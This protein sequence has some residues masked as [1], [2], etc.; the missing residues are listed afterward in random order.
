MEKRRVAVVG[1]GTVCP[2]GNSVEDAW[3]AIKSG[4]SGIGR[5]TCFDT[6]TYP[7]KIA[8]EVKGFSVEDYG[9]E[10]KAVRKMARFTQLVVASSVQAIN[11]AHLSKEELVR[12]GAGVCVG[13]CMGGL[14]AVDEGYRKLLAS[15]TGHSKISPLTVP[16]WISSEA[17]A[18]VSIF[19]GLQGPSYEVGTACASGTDAIG[20][21]ADLVKSGRLDV[22]LAGGTEASLTEFNIASLMQLQALTTSGNDNP[23][24]ASRPF[25]AT[26]DGF[27]FSEGSAILVLEEMT[28]AQKRGAHIYAEIAGYGS[29]CDAY[30]ITAPLADGSGAALAMRRALEDAAVA[31]E[32]IDYYNAHGT[33]T[34]LN[35]IAETRMLKAVF[36]ESVRSLSVSSTKSM[37]GHMIAAAGAVEAVFCV[38]AIEEGFVPPTINLEHPDTENDLDLDYTPNVGHPRKIDFAASASL[39]F[40]GHNGCLIFKAM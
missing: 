15:E 32:R 39:G 11:D 23:T 16:L 37:T 24:K 21:A 12:R 6:T 2:V 18:N 3:E 14:D 22:C 17:A 20:I 7:V 31:P 10:R 40:G 4:T 8:G 38:K 28:A 1:L 25:D 36:G 13:N 9:I 30:H 29:S 27:V 34:V 33:A 35:D 26:R 19:F 5:I